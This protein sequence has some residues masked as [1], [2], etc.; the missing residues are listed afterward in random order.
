MKNLFYIASIAVVASM[1]VISCSKSA[2]WKLD[3]EIDG[4]KEGSKIVLEAAN[5]AGY[6]Y[7]LDTLTVDS[8]GNFTTEQ[9]ATQYPDIFR[10]NFDGN[11]I[12]FPIDSIEQISLKANATDF[13]SGYQLEG[14]ENAKLIAHV[15]NRINQFLTNH[16]V[17]DLDTAKTLKREL[18]GMIMGNPSSIV[19]FYITNKQI[20]GHRLFR[21]DNRQ[22][23]G[24]I[25]AVANSYA[26]LRPD[27]PRTQFLKDL[28]LKN[29]GQFS[30][31]KDTL[32]ANTIELIDIE[33]FDE[34][35]KTRKLREVASAN[36]LVLLSFTNYSADYSQALNLALRE[37]YDAHHSAGLEVFQLGF[38]PNEF[39]WRMAAQNQ[40]WTTIY[41]GTTDKNVINYNVGQLPALFVIQNG[42]L[43]ERITDIDKLKSTVAKYL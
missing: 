30:T 17:A 6:W 10:L 21:T 5:P 2:Q 43:V 32:S 36:K 33:G 16:K 29:K 37:L 28:W 12:Y 24:I 23:L 42:A 25:G 19:A 26:E 14:S 11:Y 27:D 8:K 13:A 41:N 31:R 34:K 4:A 9:P 15:E 3:G 20:Q 1:A 35:G 7:A 18:S 40:P 38:S 39:D 22:E